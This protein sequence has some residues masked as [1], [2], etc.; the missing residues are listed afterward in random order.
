MYC[1][2]TQSHWETD[3]NQKFKRTIPSRQK[4]IGRL[5]FLLLEFTTNISQYVDMGL[6]DE[7]EEEV[8]YW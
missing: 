5:F 2:S 4:S 7:E 8:E 1:S 6:T 3:N